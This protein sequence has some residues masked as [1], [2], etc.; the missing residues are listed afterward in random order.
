MYCH[1]KKKK[2]G[3]RVSRGEIWILQHKQLDGTYIHE[4]A[5]R[6]GDK[7]SKIEQLDETTRIL[8][9]N[10]SFAQAFGKEHS[11]RVRG[12]VSTDTKAT[13]LSKFAAAAR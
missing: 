7:I 6:I 4:E 13:L 3:R 8:S 11:G 5:Q 2:Q 10:D 1:S 9:E 12:I